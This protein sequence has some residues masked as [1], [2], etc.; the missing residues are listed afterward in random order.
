MLDASQ[1]VSEDMDDYPGSKKE[2]K[3]LPGAKGTILKNLKVKT[4]T[5][6]D[7]L[8]FNLQ[9]IKKHKKKRNIGEKDLFQQQI[10]KEK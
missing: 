9:P 10:V 4:G 5:L 7:F 6:D 8:S 1:D 3:K 2:Y